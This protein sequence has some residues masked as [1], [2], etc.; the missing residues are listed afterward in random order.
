MA[1]PATKE[2]VRKVRK[3][4]VRHKALSVNEFTMFNKRKG[5]SSIAENKKAG[6]S[7]LQNRQDKSQTDNKL[8]VEIGRDRKQKKAKMNLKRQT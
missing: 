3:N 8:E 6:H 4:A 1:H 7:Q 5:T 2:P